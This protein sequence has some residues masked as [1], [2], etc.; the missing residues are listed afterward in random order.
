MY[1]IAF[2]SPATVVIITDVLFVMLAS[3]VVIS[4]F[5]SPCFSSI[6]NSSIN[7]PLVPEPSSRD[8]T[9]IS[10][11]AALTVLA[12]AVAPNT[13]AVKT[14]AIF[15]FMII[16]LLFLDSLYLIFPVASFTGA[17]VDAL[18]KRKKRSFVKN[19]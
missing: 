1:P 16:F 11:L 5:S 4:T 18:C 17:I 13:A 7:A 10:P 9:V 8:T 14:A 12:N 2:S 15:F 6:P 3:S 19:M